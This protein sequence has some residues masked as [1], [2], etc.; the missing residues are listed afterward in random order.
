VKL[1][2]AAATNIGRVLLTLGSATAADLAV[3]LGV[4]GAAIRKTLDQLEAQGFV[5]GDE[6]A[7]FGPAAVAASRGRGRPARVFSLTP[8]GKSYFGAHEDTL[9]VTALKF[10]AEKGGKDL[11]HQF[12]EQ[13]ATNFQARHENISLLPT[14]QERAQAL[15]AALNDEGYATAVAPGLGDS[16]QISQHHCPLGDVAS[17]FPD[18]CEAETRMISELTGVHVTRLATIAKGS[19]VCTTLVPHTRREV[20]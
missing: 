19:P 11:V 10:M 14:I 3:E 9:A 15:C 8:A 16:T 6:R 2:G 12:A 5:Q 18:V 4:S 13:L 7:P 20:G 17:E 1:A